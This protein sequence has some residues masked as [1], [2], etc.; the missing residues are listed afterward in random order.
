MTTV[1]Q[2]VKTNY[3]T[4]LIKPIVEFAAALKTA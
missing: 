3:E 1:M 2:H 4:D